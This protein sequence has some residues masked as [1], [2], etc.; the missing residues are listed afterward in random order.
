MKKSIAVAAFLF[1]VAV[2]T[3]VGQTNVG[4]LNTNKY[5]SLFS[6]SKKED[7]VDSDYVWKATDEEIVQFGVLNWSGKEDITGLVD[8]PLE[9]AL[10]SYYS[11]PV[12]KSR[13]K[14]ADT[15]LPANNPKLADQKLGAAVF[16]EIQ[17]MRF[18]GNTKAVNNLEAILKFIT[19]R[20]KVTRAEVEAFYRD[21]IRA[22]IASV[23]D[24]EFKYPIE[25]VIKDKRRGINSLPVEFINE[26]KQRIYDFC[27]TPTTANFNK[28]KDMSRALALRTRYADCSKAWVLSKAF[29]YEDKDLLSKTRNYETQITVITKT[30]IPDDNFKTMDDS[31]D[32]W[33]DT[34]IAFYHVLYNLF[35][36][37]ISEK[38]YVSFSD[39]P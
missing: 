1:V 20:K 30:I 32:F 34:N 16:Q 24:E 3:A 14:E 9:F 2:G 37:E 7:I 8:T 4:L 36:V 19:D 15:M 17:I 11:Q 33:D 13:P 35:N 12:L 31:P 39:I 5:F 10:L 18:L 22:L 25:Q 28:L 23:V 38:A 21:N 26:V 6:I 27:I 29:G